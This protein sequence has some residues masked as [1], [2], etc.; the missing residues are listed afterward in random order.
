MTGLNC[1]HS[2]RSVLSRPCHS[3]PG[4]LQTESESHPKTRAGSLVERV[5]TGT[6]TESGQTPI[7][8]RII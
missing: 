5:S 3:M 8:S 6:W 1:V 7:L 2:A 4:G